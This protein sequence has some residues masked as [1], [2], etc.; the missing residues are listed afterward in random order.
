M[1]LSSS[2]S[3]NDNVDTRNS[4]NIDFPKCRELPK[5]QPSDRHTDF[6]MLQLD[7]SQV[8]RR[9]ESLGGTIAALSL[10]MAVST[11]TLRKSPNRLHQDGAWR[12][13]VPRPQVTTSSASGLTFMI[14][15]LGRP[16]LRQ[17]SRGLAANWGRRF[18]QTRI[19]T[20]Q[21]EPAGDGLGATLGTDCSGE[22]S[23]LD[24]LA[25]HARLLAVATRPA[26]LLQSACLLLLPA[27]SRRESQR[28]LVREPS[29]EPGRIGGLAF[30]VPDRSTRDRHNA[31]ARDLRSIRQGTGRLQCHCGCLRIPN[32]L[33]GNP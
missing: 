1:R 7:V 14:A 18:G 11:E 15:R 9:V 8:F 3:S 33:S 16:A 19:G 30:K 12:M 17:L 23:R 29:G 21:G 13:P 26:F 28:S 2:V 20:F 10:D 32:V 22:S 5:F 4:P 24:P 27:P 6:Q 31:Q 25:T